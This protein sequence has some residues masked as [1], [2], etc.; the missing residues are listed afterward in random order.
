M[1]LAEAETYGMFSSLTHTIVVGMKSASHG[2]L[3]TQ[4]ICGLLNKDSAVCM[5]VCVCDVFAC[6]YCI[7]NCV[8]CIVACKK[9]KKKVS[10]Y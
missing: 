10:V 6:V 4:A 8:L 5:C 9:L 1:K 2:T 7:L 3:K